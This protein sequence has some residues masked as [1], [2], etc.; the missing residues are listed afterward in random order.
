MNHSRLQACALGLVLLAC[1]PVHADGVMRQPDW[2][3]QEAREAAA[4]IDALQALKPLYVLARAGRDPELLA[5]LQ[6]MAA[7]DRWPLPAREHVLQEFAMGLGDLQPQAVGSGV[8]SFLLGYEPQVL[9]PHEEYSALGVPLYNIPAAAAG[10]MHDW[11]RQVAATQATELSRQAADAWVAAYLSA[12]T[13]Q[14]K[15]FED[16]LDFAEPAWL[17]QL[18]GHA[19]DAL[20]KQ[21]DLTPIVARSAILL[22]D[23]EL[24]QRT[25][26]VGSGPGIAPALQAAAGIMDAGDRAAILRHAV[27]HASAVNASLALAELAPGLLHQPEAADLLFELMGH[28]ELGATAALVL[29]R[30]ADAVIH[31]RL[32]ESA[33]L[34]QGL[35]SQRAA[36]ALSL[37]SQIRGGSER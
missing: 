8:M 18:A 2:T 19:F 25:I 33:A 9:V 34:G 30:S 24:L 10:V 35:R 28:A 14:R 36:L 21:P 27:H 22:A 31:D 7:N 32:A 23:A 6:A 12:G 3:Q 26:Q 16:T 1:I 17:R 13:A 37:V 5:E 20:A 4:A 29:S 11:A 15:G